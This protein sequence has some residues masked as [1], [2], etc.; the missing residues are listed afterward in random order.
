MKKKFTFF[1]KLM[2][3]VAIVMAAGMLCGIKAGSSDPREHIVIAFF[4]LAYPFFLLANLLMLI[5]WALR[6]K[7]MIAILTIIIICFGGHTLIATFGLFGNAGKSEKEE[8]SLVRMMTYNVHNFKPFGDDNTEAIKEKMLA[9]VNGQNPDIICFQEFYTRYKGPYDTI[10]SLKKILNTQYY[11][12]LPISKSQ[13]EAI[14]LAIFSRYPIKN[15]GSILFNEGYGGNESI[16]VDLEINKHTVRVYNVHLQ[17]ISFDKEDYTYFEKATKEM[18]P[19]IG[20]SK[21]I[22]R[23]LKSAF[24]KRSTQV[25]IMKAHMRTCNTPYIVAGDFN[26]TPASYAVTQMTDSL[27]NAFLKKGQGLGRTYNGK[28]PNFQIDYIASTKEIDIVNYHIIEAKLSDHFP[29]RS[30]LRLK[31]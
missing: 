24:K 7:W 18:E 5:Y 11:Y 21:R 6:T 25:D 26:D 28:F 9:I 8:A 14:G 3:F 10:D 16:Y 17:S 20:S 1:D 22:V 30:D 15:K 13:R 2:L 12:F 23:M 31:N 4:G 27:N 29:V 19:Q